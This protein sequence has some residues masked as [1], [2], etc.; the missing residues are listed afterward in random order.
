MAANTLAPPAP[1]PQL[2]VHGAEIVQN[3][4]EIQ[5]RKD[6]AFRLFEQ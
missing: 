5:H 2:D 6:A 1:V 3:I 4:L